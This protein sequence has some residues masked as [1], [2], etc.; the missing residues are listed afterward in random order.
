MELPAWFQQQEFYTF[1]ALIAVVLLL[2]GVKRIILVRLKEKA[3]SETS[4]MSSIYRVLVLSLNAPLTVVIL[5]IFL[6]LARNVFTW[7]GLHEQRV[8]VFLDG[9]VEAGVII[10]LFLFAERFF[11]YSLK[12]YREQSTLVKNTSAIAGGALRAVLATLTVLII[13]RN[14]GQAGRV[15]HLTPQTQSA[16]YFR[17]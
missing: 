8:P 4:S 11:T 9:V 15:G 2:F 7:S 1:C 10:A 3:R 5:L 13:L 12:R 17:T 14:F 6:L 16:P